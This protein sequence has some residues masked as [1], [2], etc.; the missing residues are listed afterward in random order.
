VAPP[1]GR[2]ILVPSADPILCLLRDG[3]PAMLRHGL[4]AAAHAERDGAA[5]PMVLAALLH[6]IGHALDLDDGSEDDRDVE[7][8]AYGAGW[9][10]LWLPSEV[11]EPVRL[12]IEAKRYV[13]ARDPGAV[14][15]LTARS[16]A[17]LMLQGGPMDAAECAGFEGVPGFAAA[18]ALRGWDDAPDLGAVDLRP[19]DAY[20]PMLERWMAVPRLRRG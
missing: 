18:L 7:H 19:L 17:S 2:L 5:E 12:H 13:C 11:T 14:A 8:A 3:D 9:L 10:S 15:R 6:D 1:G 20:R 16:R 4:T